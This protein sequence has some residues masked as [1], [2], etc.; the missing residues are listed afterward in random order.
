MTVAVGGRVDVLVGT[1]TGV[2]VAVGERVGVLLSAG[3][4]VSFAAAVGGRVGV[5]LGAGL[6]VS[7]GA[8][9][10]V[11]L[12]SGTIVTEPAC[13]TLRTRVVSSATCVDRVA[14]PAPRAR[15][16]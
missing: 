14:P 6:G 16:T 3:P 8:A 4:G 15:R 9:V 12:G 10:G 2:S 13:S 7:V 11:L 1:G 5:L